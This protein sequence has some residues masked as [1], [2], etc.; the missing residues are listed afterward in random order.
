MGGTEHQARMGRRRFI[1]RHD[2]EDAAASG[3]PVRAGARDVVT[4]EAAQ[5][6][7]DL[8]VHIQRD[9]AAAGAGPG[10]AAR[11]SAAS[12]QPARPGPSQRAVSG[13]DLRRAVR[14]AVIA[15]LGSEPA[16]LDAVIERVLR[17]RSS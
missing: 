15:E 6:A 17:S 4:S 11:E 14:S 5:R 8:G 7:D 10:S 13:D 2:I 3:Q 16:G 9:E 1:T 12:G